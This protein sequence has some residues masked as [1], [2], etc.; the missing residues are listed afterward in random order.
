ME[1]KKVKNKRKINITISILI[2]ICFINLISASSLGSFKQGE[3]VSLYQY[4]DSCSYVKLTSIQEPD[5]TITIM[6]TNMTKIGT[7]YNYTFCNT[8]KI[9][10]YR[11]TVC[12]DKNSGFV[13]ENIDF[14]ITP[15]GEQG[16]EN[17]I[18]FVFIILLIYGIT[19]ISFFYGRNIPMTILG[20]MAM[21][22]LGVYTINNG[23]IIFR[24][25]LTNYISYLTIGI[26]FILS[27]WAT[28][29]QFDVI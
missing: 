5:S 22:F 6:N 13:C 15:S 9:G 7:E 12:G 8:T 3:C 14:S 10:N 16:I 23:I 11:Y 28:L 19:F 27:S 18:F 4:C 21:M 25:T 20:G 1:N 29:E 2:S 26:G 17:T 24:D